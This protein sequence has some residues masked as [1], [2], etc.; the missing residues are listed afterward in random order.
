MISIILPHL[1]SAKP[2]P[3]FKK[4]LE[5]N[6][7]HEYELIEVIDWTDV[8]AAY[9]HGASMAK[10]DIIIMM[11]DD[12]FVAPGWDLNFVKYVKPKTFVMMWLVESGYIPVNARMIEYDCGRE[13]ETFDYD[14]F[15]R[16][17]DAVDVPEV[18]EGAYGAWMPIGFHKST[19]IPFP[20]EK[21]Y[22]HSN[23]ID[24]IDKMLPSMG[25]TPLKVKSFAYHLQGFSRR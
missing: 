11:N 18:V 5:Q 25:Y 1:S 19:W 16:F 10:Y 8:Y 15:I 2:V 7:V 23:D 3:Q 17:V 20:N 22:P 9:N 24:L 21:K 6:T 14:K 4:Y 13:L 12:M